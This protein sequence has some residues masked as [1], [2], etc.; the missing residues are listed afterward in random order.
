MARKKVKRKPNSNM[1]RAHRLATAVLSGYVIAYVTGREEYFCHLINLN[2]MKE[3][4][5]TS[6]LFKSISEIPHAWGV[7]IASVCQDNFDKKYIQ[8]EF[9]KMKSK[10]YQRDLIEYLNQEHSKLLKSTNPNHLIGAG[11]IASPIGSE[12]TDEQATQIF[13]M[14]GAWGN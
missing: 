1:Q 8:S 13:E 6:V 10:Y 7:L 4:Q 11:W 3:V 9:H 14:I 2:Q 12:V 5:V